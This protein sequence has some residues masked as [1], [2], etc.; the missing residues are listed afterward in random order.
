MKAAVTMVVFA[1]AI[2]KEE[3]GG[4]ARTVP[5]EKGE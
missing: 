2:E 3:I 5:G 1:A 4:M